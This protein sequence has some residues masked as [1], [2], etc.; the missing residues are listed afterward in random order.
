MYKYEGND[1]SASP[2]PFD[3]DFEAQLRDDEDTLR[4]IVLRMTAALVGSCRQCKMISTDI[5]D[6]APIYC[7][8]SNDLCYF[9]KVSVDC[10]LACGEYKNG[11]RATGD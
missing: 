6:D 5:E 11:P 7:G 2:H 8:K 3:H 10:C 1:S 4:R 9:R